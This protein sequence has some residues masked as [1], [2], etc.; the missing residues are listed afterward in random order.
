MTAK[1][2]KP[3]QAAKPKTAKPSAPKVVL[4]EDGMTTEELAYDIA[5][6]P[7]NW[8][9]EPNSNLGW[10]APRDLIGTPLEK[11]VRDM[12]LAAKYGIYW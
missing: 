9:K 3:S 2:A 6:D 12:L 4:P 10:Q 11:V 7:E 1:K 8:L 5:P